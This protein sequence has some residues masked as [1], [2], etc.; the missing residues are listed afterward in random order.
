MELITKEIERRLLENGRTP[1][2]DNRPV[3]KFFN[4][5]GAATWLISQADPEEPDILFGLA[6]LGFGCP[7]F[8][9]VRLSE[10]RSVKGSLGLG[11]ERDL[12]FE[13]RYPLSV[14]AEA[15]RL[16]GS[17]VTATRLLDDAALRLGRLETPAS[18]ESGGQAQD[19]AAGPS[20]PE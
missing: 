4:P 10:L 14:Y 13:A 2:Q 20:D 6:D 19:Q 12:Y 5:C 17:I 16:A 9:S 1:D 8:G 3:V 18:G 15:A 7:E 11:I